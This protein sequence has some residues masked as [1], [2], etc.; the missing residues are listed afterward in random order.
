MATSSISTP[1][2]SSAAATGLPPSI[3]AF[4]SER[5]RPSA[6]NNGLL[7]K[8]AWTRRLTT[9]LVADQFRGDDAEG[10]VAQM[11]LEHGADS[12]V[13]ILDENAATLSALRAI[14]ANLAEADR[15]IAAGAARWLDETGEI[16]TTEVNL[17][18]FA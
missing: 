14:V 1:E 4:P 3:L 17:E 11:I 9:A 5:V 7:D 13:R 10:Q 6:P 18:D 8:V 16:R 2:I 15:R 12:I